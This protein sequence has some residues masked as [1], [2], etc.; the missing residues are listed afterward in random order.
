M[1]YYVIS[2]IVAMFRLDVVYNG[3][4]W[5]VLGGGGGGGGGDG[6]SDGGD[7]GCGDWC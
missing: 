2:V 4:G 6:S 3:S 7:G 1:C 5:G